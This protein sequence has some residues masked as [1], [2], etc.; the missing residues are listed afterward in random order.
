MTMTTLL[1]T[2][3][4]S[5]LPAF[6]FGICVLT[7]SRDEYY[8]STYVIMSLVFTS[9]SVILGLILPA[10]MHAS[11]FGYPW[12]WLFIAG[13]LPWLIALFS[14]ALLNITPLCVGQDNGD[15]TNDFS[16]CT[17]YTMLVMFLYSPIELV[18]LTLS[19]FVGGKIL[20]ALI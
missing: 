14:L 13:C 16:L 9:T 20:R 12:L 2:S 1:L 17:M 4:F 7:L 8:W 15:G 19:A 5:A 3:L 11:R 6:L 18:L 10:R